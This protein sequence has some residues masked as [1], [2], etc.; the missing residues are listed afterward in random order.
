MVNTMTIQATGKIKGRQTQPTNQ[1]HDKINKIISN[2]VCFVISTLG[3][4]R[5][6]TTTH[7]DTDKPDTTTVQK[8]KYYEIYTTS[9]SPNL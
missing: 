7:T 5:K 8:K 6:C 2:T 3:Y 9:S 1:Y 4:Q